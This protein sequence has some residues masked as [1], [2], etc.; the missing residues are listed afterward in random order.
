MRID[1]AGRRIRIDGVANPIAA[2]IR[3]AVLRNGATVIEG[4]LPDIAIFSLPLL[5]AET[6]D[7]A[8]LLAIA[9]ATCRDMDERGNGRVLF[10]LS[11]AAGMPMRRHPAFSIAMG[12][13]LTT[14]RTLAMAHGPNVLVNALGVGAVGEPL[15]AGDAAMLGHASVPRAGTVSEVADTA[16]FFCDP[17]NTYTTGQMLSVDGGWT[18]GYGRSF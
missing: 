16:L 12:T 3:D 6:P 18:A 15:L 11:A 1:L 8:P 4:S 7:C 13:A 17:L 14:M 2:A 5:P 10:V 9:T